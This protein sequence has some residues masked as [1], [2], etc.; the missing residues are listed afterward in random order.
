MNAVPYTD[1]FVGTRR[2]FRSSLQRASLVLWGLTLLVGT[3]HADWVKE[4]AAIDGQGA[5]AL[6]DAYPFFVFPSSSRTAQLVFQSDQ[7]A[8]TVTLEINC[9]TIWRG[10][11]WDYASVPPGVTLEALGSYAESGAPYRPAPMAACPPGRVCPKPPP[12]LPANSFAIAPGQSRLLGLRIT[13]G[14]APAYGRYS[15]DIE[16][17]GPRTFPSITQVIFS[18]LPAVPADAG[19]PNCSALTALTARNW[20]GNVKAPGPN[21][22]PA[23]PLAATARD[24]YDKKTHAPAQ[25]MW[26]IG[27]AISNENAVRYDISPP[28]SPL[29]PNQVELVFANQTAWDKEMDVYDGGLCAIVFPNVLRQGQSTQP[30]V[31]SAVP[32]SSGDVI[33]GSPMTT[34]LLKRRVCKA[35]LVGVCADS[36]GWDNIAVLSSP[37]LW[38]LF[39]GRRLTITWVYS[40][41]EMP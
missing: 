25:T 8:G 38:S 34:V 33:N 21:L 26:Q 13:A 36:G 10:N 11:R 1:G 19:T 6:T 28:S 32:H 29:A 9:C 4:F 7:F 2:L 12:P 17:Y 15:A 3:A 35:G 14:P 41:G 27:D 31:F 30:M 20:V 18:I 22:V 24:L 37:P 23:Q 5:E 40:T 39:G 16:A